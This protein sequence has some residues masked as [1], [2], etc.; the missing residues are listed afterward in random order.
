MFRVFRVSGVSRVSRVF[1]V[2]RVFRVLRVPLGSLGCLGFGVWL[3]LSGF[4]GSGL[5][6]PNKPWLWRGEPSRY[7]RPNCLDS[8]TSFRN[9]ATHG[10]SEAR[11]SKP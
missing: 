10:P 3:G 8:S 7:M 9:R 11:S 2:V 5:F 6:S 1:R 4:R